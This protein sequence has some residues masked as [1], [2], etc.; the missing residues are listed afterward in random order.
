MFR[1]LSIGARIGLTIA[2]LIVI[3][4]VST[5][6]VVRYLGTM[7][8]EVDTMYNQHFQGVGFLLE[9]DRDAYQSRLALGHLLAAPDVDR[10]EKLEEVRTNLEQVKQ[11]FD[12][13]ETIYRGLGE[14]D[15]PQLPLFHASYAALAKATEATVADATSGR[16]E[17]AYARYRGS[18]AEAFAATR[19]AMDELTGASQ[20]FAESDYAHFVRMKRSASWTSSALIAASILVSVVLGFLVTRSV[21]LPLR[22]MTRQLD[23]TARGDLTSELYRGFTDRPDEIGVLA[24]GFEQT[25]TKLREVVGSVQQAT[26]FLAQQSQELRGSSQQIS[27]TTTEQAASVAEVSATLTEFDQTLAANLEGAMRTEGIATQLAQEAND[28]VQ[29]VRRAVEEMQRI[30]A[31]VGAIGE[32]SRQTDLLALNA[33]IEAARAGVAGRGFAVVASEVRKLAESSK[34]VAAGVMTTA[35]RTAGTSQAAREKIE[36]LAPSIQR[37]AEL[38]KR[39]RE[40]SAEQRAGVGQVTTAM[41]QLDAAAQQNA[42]LSE[43][44]ASASELLAERADALRQLMQFFTLAATAGRAPRPRAG[45]PLP[46]MAPAPIPDAMIAGS[47]TA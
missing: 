35:T 2:S 45:K 6:L 15:S 10:K 34:E 44:M 47:G 27:A 18:Y 29:T 20:G 12:R 23:A 9:A 14:E 31:D 24:R 21:T 36:Q 38:V 46:R 16:T 19:G 33:A 26:E 4:I 28:S 8:R 22:A 30:A 32:I 1:K 37:T 41:T 40:S 17:A 13:F 39:I 25:N 3:N 7:G 11:R 5:L 43:E 42:S